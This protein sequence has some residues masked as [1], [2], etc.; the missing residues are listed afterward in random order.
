MRAKNKSREEW[1]SI[2]SGQ[3]QSGL[4]NKEYAQQVGVKLCSF[5]A[6]KK[7]LKSEVAESQARLVEV[8]FPVQKEALLLRFPNGVELQIPLSL[9]NSQLQTILN[10]AVTK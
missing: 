5:M 6:W 4:T 10:W 3:Q 7:R 8:T 9:G 2:V 1:V